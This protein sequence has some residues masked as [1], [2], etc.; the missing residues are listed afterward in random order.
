MTHEQ[1]KRYCL[2]YLWLG[3]TVYFLIG[4]GYAQKAIDAA[5]GELR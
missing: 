5:L 2:R 3:K 4:A 1:Q